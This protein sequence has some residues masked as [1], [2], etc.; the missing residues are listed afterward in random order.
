M[1]SGV[2]GGRSGI[3][4]GGSGF[5]WVVSPV[6]IANNLDRWWTGFMRALGKE[7]EQVG[8]KITDWS[9]A[10]HPWQN[11][12]GAAERSLTTEVMQEGGNWVILHHADPG[13]DAEGADHVFWME[14]RWDGRYGVL[15]ISLQHH[16]DDVMSAVKRAMKAVTIASRF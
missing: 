7:L 13:I 2:Q 8:V 16:Y 1:R 12:T 6:E 10:N 4:G 9:K 5:Y 15:R 11:I 14:V 3:A